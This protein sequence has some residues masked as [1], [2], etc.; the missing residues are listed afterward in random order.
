MLSRLN[1]ADRFERGRTPAELRETLKVTGELRIPAGAG[2][3]DEAL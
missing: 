2:I 1:Q 3:S